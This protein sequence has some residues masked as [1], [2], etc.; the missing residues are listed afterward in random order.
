VATV[1]FGLA[2]KPLATVSLSLTS[3]PIV[4]FLIESQN[5]GGEEFSYLDIKTG[6]YNLVIWDLKSL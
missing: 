4:D 2:L 3:K 6:C 5:Q 1:F